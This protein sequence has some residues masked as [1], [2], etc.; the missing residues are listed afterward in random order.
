MPLRLRTDSS[1]FAAE[2]AAFAGAKREAAAD[3]DAV[4]LEIIE[5]VRRRGDAALIDCTKRFDRLELTPATM[6][7]SPAEIAAAARSCDGETLAAL[8]FAA[9]RIEGYHR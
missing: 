8:R 6:R 3:V 5:A 9:E 1:R 7:I 4:V 2:F